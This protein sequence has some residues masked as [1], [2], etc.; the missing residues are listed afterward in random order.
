M[1]IPDI[2]AGRGGLS[3]IVSIPIAVC[4]EL[5]TQTVSRRPDIRVCSRWRG[6]PWVCSRLALRRQS[7]AS[8][9]TRMLRSADPLGVSDP[10][11]IS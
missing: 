7:H 11:K 2:V 1:S 8:L 3:H 9:Q 6:Q 4:L 10:C 5:E